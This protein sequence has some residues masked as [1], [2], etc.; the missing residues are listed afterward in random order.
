MYFGSLLILFLP[1]QRP[2]DVAGPGSH[3]MAAPEWTNEAEAYEA[4]Y[5]DVTEVYGPGT[6]HFYI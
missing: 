2:C 3:M 5:W 1:V 4:D 6:G